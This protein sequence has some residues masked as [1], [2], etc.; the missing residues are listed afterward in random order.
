[1]HVERERN[2]WRLTNC[3]EEVKGINGKRLH[4]S[5]IPHLY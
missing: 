2:K 4:L 3:P 5:F 1:M